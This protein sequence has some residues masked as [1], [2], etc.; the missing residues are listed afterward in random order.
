MN[1]DFADILLEVIE[2]RASDLHLTAARASA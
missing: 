1:I 2:R